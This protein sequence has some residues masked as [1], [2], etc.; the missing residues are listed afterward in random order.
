[1]QEREGGRRERCD[2]C[3]REGVTS[4]MKS[5]D[6]SFNRSINFWEF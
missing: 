5:S 3:L 2:V 1:M 6:P 4:R